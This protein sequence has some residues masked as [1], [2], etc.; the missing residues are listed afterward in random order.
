MPVVE[1][2][3]WS[4]ELWGG[5]SKAASETQEA[6]GCD[7]LVLKL[8]SPASLGLKGPDWRER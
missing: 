5:K 7:M 2:F 1:G 3:H 8:G 6:A 4:I